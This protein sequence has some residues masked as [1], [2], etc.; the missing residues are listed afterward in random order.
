ML[1]ASQIL[2]RTIAL[3]ASAAALA[4]CGQSGPLFLPTEPAAAQRATLPQTLNPVPSAPQPP[5]PEPSVP[6][7]PASSPASSPQL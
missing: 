3:A 2:V 6:A 5:A 4:A 1:R 7:T